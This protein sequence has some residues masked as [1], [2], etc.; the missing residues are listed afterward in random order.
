M[1]HLLN[2]GINWVNN[3]SLLH[4]VIRF[5]HEMGFVMTSL[6]I[7][8]D[9]RQSKTLFTIKNADRKSLESGFESLLSPVGGQ[10]A[11]ET[12]VFNYF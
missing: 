3:L 4:D 11:I 8:P 10:M 6:E 12:S 2:S 1:S 9:R 5:H 7:T